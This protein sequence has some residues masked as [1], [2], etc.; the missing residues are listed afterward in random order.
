MTSALQEP[1]FQ[2]DDKTLPSRKKPDAFLYI[3]NA[4]F[5]SREPYQIQKMV[6]AKEL[7]Q[8]K[9]ISIE[10]T[11]TVAQLLGKL[12]KSRTHAAI[13]FKNGKYQGTITKRFILN[14]RMEPKKVKIENITK[15]RS[16]SKSPFHVPML[17]ESTTLQEICRLMAAADSH[18]LPV[19][20]NGKVLGIVHTM[21]VLTNISS[22][23]KGLKCEELAS[24]KI[25]TITEGD[26][27]GKAI[28]LF[29]RNGIDHLPVIDD[30]GKLTG[31][32][33]TSDLIENSAFWGT[34]SQK[35][36]SAARHQGNKNSGYDS[37]E[38]TRMSGLPISNLMSRKN[39]CCTQPSTTIP[40]A[41]KLM[42]E[43]D[44]P[45]IILVKNN[46]PVGILTAKD[47]LQDYAK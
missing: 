27:I 20:E 10:I 3:V 24:M 42:T 45:S 22:A 29:S 18:I 40:N 44:V 12:K 32:L 46:E 14:S 37:G 33:S 41:I 7:M 5:K 47:V 21:D 2:I 30:K 23:Y 34:A 16:K 31:M 13:V 15:R 6:T 25:T 11:D 8:K 19:I 1:P 39:M 38:K 28:T 26:D 43:N 17:K 35:I 9:Y 4:T 36:S